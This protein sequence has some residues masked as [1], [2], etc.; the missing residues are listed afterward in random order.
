[1]GEYSRH[2]HYTIDL[3]KPLVR[4]SWGT[5]LARGDIHAD[6]IVLTLTRGGEPYKPTVYPVF[7]GDMLRA[8][9]KTVLFDQQDMRYDSTVAL[10][11]DN[12]CYQVPGRF[13]LSVQLYSG[14]NA[15][16][17]VLVID[18]YIQEFRSDDYIFPDYN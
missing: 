2:H 11:L 7:I 15:S 10:T 6:D 12:K 14:D 9:G 18:G 17:T 8:D 16:T 13:T 4:H 1:M 5:L 3:D